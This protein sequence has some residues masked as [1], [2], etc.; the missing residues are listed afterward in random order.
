MRSYLRSAV[1]VVVS[2]TVAVGVVTI[3][4]RA[5]DGSKALRNRVKD[6]E[7]ELESTQSDF[8]TAMV[9]VDSLQTTLEDTQA[10][11]GDAIVDVEDLKEK[12]DYVTLVQG[13][14]DGLSGPHLVFEGC[15][16]HIRSGSGNSTDGSADLFAQTAIPDTAPLGL[17]NLIV[18]YNEQ[19]SFGGGPSLGGSHN[20][21]VGP[22]HK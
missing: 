9:E 18:G 20:L 13:P 16:V 14:L 22:G 6:L 11:L 1:T 21:V 7:R 5:A 8:A 2:V 4:G 3:P 17:G 19:P 15:N 10:Q 12:L